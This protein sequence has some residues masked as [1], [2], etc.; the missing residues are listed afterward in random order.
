MFNKNEQPAGVECVG[1]TTLEEVEKKH[2]TKEFLR[3][4]CFNQ[5]FIL[6]EHEVVYLRKEEF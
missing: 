2:I 4:A 3:Q 6:D 1:I 5:H